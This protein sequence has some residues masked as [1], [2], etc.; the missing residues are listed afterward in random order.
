MEE[1]E[2]Q[3]LFKKNNIKNTKH[4]NLVLDVLKESQFPITTEDIY[5]KLQ[6][7]G[8]HI[9]LS[10][11]YRIL[12]VFANKGMVV[13]AIISEGS[14]AMVELQHLEHKHHLICKECNKIV[15]I[16]DCPFEEFAK[17][18][19]KK[20]DFDITGHKLEIYGYCPACK[21]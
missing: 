20:T 7:R 15:A 13:K 4:R 18:L 2:N 21:E 8:A 11:I 5:L 10:T 19:E 14:K 16:E 3:E 6:E 1:F 9:S 12:D 17:A